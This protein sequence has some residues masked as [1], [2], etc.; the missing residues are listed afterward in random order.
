MLNF[1]RTLSTNLSDGL[2]FRQRKY[3]KKKGGATGLSIISYQW[4]DLWMTEADTGIHFEPT[5]DDFRVPIFFIAQ[6]CSLFCS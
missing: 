4:I 6:T 3:M 2:F 1:D 5:T